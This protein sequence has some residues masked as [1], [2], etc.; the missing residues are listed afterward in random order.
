MNRGGNTYYYQYNAHGDVV[1]LTNSSGQVVNAYTYD[2]WG[3]I[4]SE[5]ETVEN[6]YL[7]AGYRYDEET[8]LYYLQH[9]YY[10]SEI[11]RFLTQDY[12]SSGK[13]NHPQSLN[14]YVYCYDNPVLFSDYDGL[15]GREVHYGLT[16]MW[17]KESGFG[18]Q[19]ALTIA[20]ACAS[21]DRSPYKEE[22]GRHLNWS[23]NPLNPTQ[24]Q[25]AA[26]EKCSATRKRDLQALGRG[27]HSIQDAIAHGTFPYLNRHQL[28]LV[29]PD[30]ATTN[31]E[32]G[33]LQFYLFNLGRL[34]KTE[35]ASK[36]YL[37]GYLRGVK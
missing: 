35:S 8:G 17:A 18:S 13:L 21:V 7:Y 24:E 22:T 37:K 15:W 27:L 32:Y 29:K 33:W 26:Q 34:E 1:S 36:A 9:R 5:T 23:L 3:K 30:K 25:Y 14:S 2:P 4:L 12:E 28:L 6:S 11:C 20:K 19:D 16:Y 31:K 10:D